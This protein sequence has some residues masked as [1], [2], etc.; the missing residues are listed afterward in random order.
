M[1]NNDPHPPPYQPDY[2]LAWQSSPPQAAP[3]PYP[4]LV[5]PRWSAPCEDDSAPAHD[6]HGDLLRLRGAYRVLRRAATFT[7]LGYF[8]LFLLLS[9]Y[10]PDLMAHPIGGGG[11]NVGLL[12][13]LCQ[14]PVAVL[15][16]TVYERTAERTV[17]PLAADLRD[18][19]R[20]S[21]HP[22]PHRRPRRHDD[23][24]GR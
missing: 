15:A 2:L 23:R 16:I 14:L 1:P 6:H 18:G 8:T 13:G 4:P 20:T 19:G 3:A 10:A 7:A 12:L 22:R 17:D 5:P 24:A 21:A 9:A 11:L